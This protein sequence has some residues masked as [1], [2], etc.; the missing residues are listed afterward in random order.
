[1]W[2]WTTK[3]VTKKETIALRY[4][5]LRRYLSLHAWLGHDHHSSSPTVYHLVWHDE[6][7]QRNVPS[8]E[9][10]QAPAR[11][12]HRINSNTV[13]VP[14]VRWS[15]GILH[16]SVNNWL[17]NWIFGSFWSSSVVW[18]CLRPEGRP[19]R[20]PVGRAFYSWALRHGHGGM[21]MDIHPPG[22]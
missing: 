2:M 11:I 3:V 18:E 15:G 9:F 8:E 21:G 6:R 22:Y 19:F 17:I 4:C 5:I 1:M 14:G 16:A 7:L 13:L 10:L 20:L 12:S